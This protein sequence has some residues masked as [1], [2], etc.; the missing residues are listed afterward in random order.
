MKIAR[1]NQSKELL[2]KGELIESNIDR[3]RLHDNGN[4]ETFE[5]IEGSKLGI[6]N[7]NLLGLELIELAQ[8]EV[9]FDYLVIAG[10][11]GGGDRHG[12]GGGAGGFLYDSAPVVTAQSYTITVG[13]GGLGG[14]HEGRAD[15]VPRGI[16]LAGGNSVFDTF[17]ALG[18]GG[19]ATYDGYAPVGGSGGG[20]AGQ[21][22][23]VGIAGT[24]G[25]GNAGGNGFISAPPGGGGGGAGAVG[26]NASASVG[27]AGGDGLS[28]SIS[29]S[30][31]FYAGGGGG[32][33][34]LGGLGGAGGNG[35]GGAGGDNGLAG[36]AG[37][38]NT[39]GG[40]GATRS[41][42]VVSSGSN[43]GSGIVIIKYP[44]SYTLT[45]GG[46]LISS[47]TTS[48]AFKVTSFTAGNG[49]INFA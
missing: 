42:P 17:T 13:V 5:Y 12:G 38:P 2:I 3:T 49:D 8:L 40:G 9:L 27:G 32:G 30:A 33:S 14:D 7:N 37:T 16:G 20:G 43:G 48:G 11:G 46:S 6:K 29:G 22:S 18:G 26:A 41:N 19:G 45:I 39:G 21:N 1:I 34:D 35:G 36:T 47:T 23:T 4:I 25:Q 24:T 28:N 31:V 10:G 15:P 44:S